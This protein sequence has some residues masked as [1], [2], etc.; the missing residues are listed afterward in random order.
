MIRARWG[1]HLVVRYLDKDKTPYKIETYPEQGGH[2]RVEIS[3]EGKA[4]YTHTFE[5][6]TVEKAVE[7]AWDNFLKRVETARKRLEK[8][9][10]SQ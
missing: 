8:R 6:T 4:L 2:L 1:M 5:N 10:K 3:K 7:K 9:P